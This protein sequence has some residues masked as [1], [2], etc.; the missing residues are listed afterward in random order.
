MD[1]TLNLIQ[2]SLVYLLLLII[3][4]VMKKCRIHQSKLVLVAS[5][6]M[7]AQ[8]FLAGL[9]LT[10]IFDHPHPLFTMLYLG[11]IT[12]FSIHTVLSKHKDLNKKFKRIISLS[13]VVCGISILA[14]YIIVVLGQS[15]FDPK[16]A[17]PLSGMI[18]GNVVGGIVLGLKNLKENLS[19]QRAKI[20]TLMNMG[21]TPQK[22]L[23]PLINRAIETATLPTIITMT[24]MGIIKLPGMMAGQILAGALPMTAILYQISVLIAIAAATCLAVF[25]SLYFGYKTLWNERN[26]LQI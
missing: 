15:F 14:F 2:F 26:Q 16:Y 11:V 24:S 18:V 1:D 23:L 13:L 9:I 20:D 10:Y 17:I 7:T 5:F 6:R 4:V 12:G 22:A 19:T 8:L 21:V 3:L 25:C